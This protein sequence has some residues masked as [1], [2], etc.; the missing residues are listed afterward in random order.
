MLSRARKGIF[1][2]PRNDN[3]ISSRRNWLKTAALA[4]G[5]ACL[6][7]CTPQAGPRTAADLTDYSNEEYVWLS[8]QA[9]NSLFQAHDHVALRLAGEEL[10]V[11]VTIGGPNTI[12]IPSLVTSLETTAARRPAGIM[13]LGWDPSALIAPINKVIESGVH[14]ICVDCDVPDSKRLAFVGTDWFELGVEQAEAMVKSL[15]GRKGKVALIGLTEQN[16]D[17]R[18]FAGFRS[19]AEKAGLTVLEPQHDQGNSAIAARLSTTFIQSTPDL[20]GIAGFDSQSGPG[21]G[22]AIKETGKAGKVLGT[23]VDADPP[24]LTL[25]KEGVLTACVGQKR[26]LFTYYGLRLLFDL[27]HSRVK[28]SK[29]DKLAGLYPVPET[30]YTG[31]YTVTRENV[32]AF[33]G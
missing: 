8:P 9:N 2:N 3:Q 11:Q 19:V 20:V 27:N 15:A 18:A 31:S 22:V 7:S 30:I 6:T 24:H 12:D 29:N 21:I 25:V 5:A 17:Q 26:E 1:M 4:G 28:F 33:L 16:I 32:D 10:G 14:L 23:C 13:M